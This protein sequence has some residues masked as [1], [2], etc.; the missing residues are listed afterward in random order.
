M[1]TENVVSTQPKS[2]TASKRR[3]LVFHI[4][5]CSLALSGGLL[6]GLSEHYSRFWVLWG[7]WLYVGGIA[8]ALILEVILLVMKRR[9]APLPGNQGESVFNGA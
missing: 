5:T 7:I 8:S 3:L 9:Q 2:Q 1:K 4:V 6:I